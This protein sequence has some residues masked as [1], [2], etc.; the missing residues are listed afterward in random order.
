MPEATLR[1]V[2][3]HDRIPADSVRGHYA[4]A[5]Q[6]LSELQAIGVDFGDVRLGAAVLQREE[7]RGEGDP[8]PGQH[9]ERR[10][11]LRGDAAPGGRQQV[12]GCGRAS[13]EGLEDPSPGSGHPGLPQPLRI[14]L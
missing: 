12:L 4:E 5:R 8:K 6:V 1:A 13:W 11:G 10:G 7:Q 2:A 9:A 14:A 3:D